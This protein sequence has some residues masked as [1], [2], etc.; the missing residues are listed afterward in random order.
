MRFIFFKASEYCIVVLSKY[1]ISAEQ[2][3]YMPHTQLCMWQLCVSFADDFFLVIIFSAEQ[4]ALEGWLASAAG[5][6]R[7]CYLCKNTNG[8]PHSHRKC[9]WKLKCGLTCVCFSHDRRTKFLY[10][11][12]LSQRLN[13]H[14]T[15]PF[16]IREKELQ[17]TAA[18]AAINLRTAAFSFPDNKWD[19]PWKSA[20]SADSK[21]LH[22]KKNI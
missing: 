22:L 10:D 13:G 15:G 7:T 8:K 3:L 11:H 12:A 21:P 2:R 19:F 20:D 9:S 14:K 16:T 5:N 1:S 4:Q 6:R 18:F 17:R